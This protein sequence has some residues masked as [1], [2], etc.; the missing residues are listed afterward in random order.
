[1]GLA[2]GGNQKLQLA[3]DLDLTPVILPL[4]IG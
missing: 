1:M 4:I 2:Y 3:L